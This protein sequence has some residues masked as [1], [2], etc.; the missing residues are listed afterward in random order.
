MQTRRVTVRATFDT[1]VVLFTIMSFN[2]DSIESD[3]HSSTTQDGDSSSGTCA[4]P[5]CKKNFLHF[6]GKR[7]QLPVLEAVRV[8][9]SS[10]VAAKA[11]DA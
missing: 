10:V 3:L 5:L 6:P 11:V 7:L 4:L 2:R 9:R 8:C 1:V